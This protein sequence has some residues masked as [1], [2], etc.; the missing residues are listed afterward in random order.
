MTV[1]RK[2]LDDLALDGKWHIPRDTLER[3][4]CFACRKFWKQ[5]T[6][7]N[8]ECEYCM[9]TQLAVMPLGEVSK[10]TIGQKLAKLEE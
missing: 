7:T 9:G 2:S 3:A 8:P 1:R 6:F 4:V 5:T 10:P